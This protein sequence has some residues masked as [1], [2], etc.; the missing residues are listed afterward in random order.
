MKAADR[1]AVMARLG[2]QRGEPVLLGL[3]EAGLDE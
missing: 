2:L 1:R 3:Y